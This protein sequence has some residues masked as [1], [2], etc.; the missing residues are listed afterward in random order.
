MI[1]NPAVRQN[2][3]PLRRVEALDAF[4]EAVSRMP[5]LDARPIGQIVG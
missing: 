1:N 4:F 2:F 5:V 3:K